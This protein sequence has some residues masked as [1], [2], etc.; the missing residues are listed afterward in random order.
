MDFVIKAGEN[1]KIICEISE[2]EAVKIAADNLK[3]DIEKV[4]PGTCVDRET[5]VKMDTQKIS[6][7]RIGTVGQAKWTENYDAEVLKDENGT[8]R[9]E[10]FQIRVEDGVLEIVGTDRRGTVYGIYTICEKLGVSPWYFFADVPVKAIRMF[11]LP[12]KFF[13]ADWP[14]VEYRGIFINDEEE[15][16]AWVQNYM[17]EKTIGVKTYEK[18]FELLLRLKANYIWPAM[19]VNSFNMY[20]ENGALAERMGIVVGTSH[21]DMLMR[22]NNREWLPWL[23]KKGYRDV[24][25][26]YSIEGRNRE[27][28]QE[29]WRESVKQNRDFEVCY[30]LGMRG[31]HDTGFETKDLAGKSEEEIRK[32]KVALLEQIIT[33]QRGILDSELKAPAMTT[34]IPYKEVLDLYDHG[35]EIP[36]DVTL[37]WANDN[38]GYIRRFPSEKEQKRSG[39]NGIYYHNSY[40]S[41]P[42]MS[43][44]FLCSIPLAHTRNELQKAW[45]EGIRKLWVLNSGAMKPLELEIS[46]FLQ[47][48][49]EIGKPDA[50]TEDVEKYTEVWADRLFSG[51]IGKTVSRLLHDFAQ[52]TNVRKLENMDQNAFSQTAYG[53]EAAL[54]IHRYEEL[55]RTGNALYAE[56]P[57]Q[58]KAAFF[59]MVLMRLQ[60]G[61]FTNLSWYYGDRSVHAM[62]KGLVQ[63]AEKYAVKC[64]Q[65]DN[66][67]RCMIHYYNHIMSEGKWNGIVNPEGF[68]PPRAAM[69]PTFKRPFQI[70]GI[71]ELAVSLWN[72]AQ[73]L[74]FC[75]PGTKWLEL[76][77][78]GCGELQV[79]LRAPEWLTLSETE[80]CVAEE[81]RILVSIQEIKEDKEGVLLVKERNSGEEIPIPVKAL[82]ID[83]M[84]AA[85]VEEDRMIAVEANLARSEDFQV[86][87]RAGRLQGNLM[88][89]VRNHRHLGQDP[90]QY[91]FYCVTSGE[92]LL[93]LHRFPSLNA[94]GRIRV[95]ISVDDSEMEIMESFANDEWRADWKSNVLHNVD[96]MMLELPLMEAGQHKLKVYAIDPYFAFSRIIIYTTERKENELAGILGD[97]RLPEEFS[98]E[99]W[100]REFYGEI[101]LSPR[102]QFFAGR[103]VKENPLSL[104][105]TVIRA[106][107]YAKG[108]ELQWYLD[109]GKKIFTENSDTQEILIDAATALAQSEFAR[110]E[111]VGTNGVF[112]YCGSE[113]FGQ[114]GCALYIRDIGQHFQAENAPGL[115]YRF[116][117][118]GGNYTLWLLCKFNIKEEADYRVSVDG[119]L[120]P[121][122]RLYGEGCLWRYEAEQIYRFVPVA[123]LQLSCGE[124][125]VQFR[126]LAGGLRF[127]RIYLGKNGKMPPADSD[128][129]NRVFAIIDKMN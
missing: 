59:Q 17:G 128:W 38:Y 19:H 16:D 111:N 44:V 102:P 118:Q 123:D 71:P 8:F 84:G 61:Y 3:R 109:R 65:A 4:L 76:A 113:S 87:H 110:I 116:R 121:A 105:D 18:I 92:F 64:R 126:S 119:E 42:S 11:R 86:I 99:K 45:N 40:W 33:D 7:V 95:G 5:A 106:E 81:K 97:Q 112:D 78:K 2:A 50:L 104:T 48:A 30:T 53:D 13:I 117:C 69:L 32:A 67:R 14:S 80:V 120:L 60:A 89:A 22:S 49:W 122:D 57:E 70:T 58:E 100:C 1:I 115:H 74:M 21:C 125:E 56:L 35:L 91:S 10:A 41:P 73:E 85:A 68:P 88:E 29:Y 15:L 101:K 107:K 124:H 98:M 39:G 24:V 93:E 20:P 129:S 43:Y 114:T 52:L 55:F 12:E 127:D 34:F 9:K 51:H 37:V 72:E 94:T 6:L 31:I 82:Q 25:Y 66:A 77:V 47:L 79:E 27:I 26:D 23:E 103:K 46:F 28:L 54:R 96:R 63:S 36:E 83:T 90:L 75:K 108:I 62:D